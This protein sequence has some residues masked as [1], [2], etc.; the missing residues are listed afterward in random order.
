M[1]Q[2][3]RC[4]AFTLMEILLVI[5]ILG[6]VT[7]VML[8][9]LSRSIRGSRIRLATRELVMAGR[10]ARSMAV[11]QQKNL[12]LDLDLSAA[13]IAVAGQDDRSALF[14]R[15][16]EGVTIESLEIASE[17]LLL[18]Q[19]TGRVTYRNNGTCTPYTVRLKDS[20]GKQ[21]TINVDALSSV[22][23]EEQ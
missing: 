4:R 15:A 19:G 8:P 22:E 12:T 13:T 3:T 10:Y 23:T 18:N 17:D 6:I 7:A 21:V 11:L 5:L 20:S 1:N 2:A 9:A 14:R 16:L